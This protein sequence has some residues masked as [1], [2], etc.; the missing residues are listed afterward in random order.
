MKPSPIQQPV[1]P[2]QQERPRQDAP[3]S[4]T[5][6]SNIAECL[7][8]PEQPPE[9]EYS[10]NWRNQKDGFLYK[11]CVWPHYAGKTHKALVSRIEE[12]SEGGNRLVHTGLFWE[13]TPDDFHATFRK[14]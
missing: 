7:D 8:T 6:V 12:K 3:T 9:S 14:E 2:E 11:H 13:G 1:I 4:M 5:A 10:G